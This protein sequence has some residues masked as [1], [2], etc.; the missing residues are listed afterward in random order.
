VTAR[1][2]GLFDELYD[3]AAIFP[4]G[5][6]PL[7]AAVPAHR[8]WL[9]SPHAATVGVF[10]CSAPRL[11]ELAGLGADFPVSVTVPDGPGG[12]PAV[13]ERDDLDVVSVEVP[14]TDDGGQALDRAVRRTQVYSEVRLADLTPSVAE[15][16]AAAGIHL[17]LRTGGA[18]AAMFPTAAALAGGIVTAVRAD[19][20]FKLTAGLH[21]ALRHRD[22][23]TGFE[24][25]GFGNVLAATAAALDGAPAPDVAAILDTTDAATVVARLRALSGAEVAAVRGRFRS[26]GTC[27]IQ[28]P[29]D[30][31]A[32]LGLL[33]A[34]TGA[35]A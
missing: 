2:G 20:P 10:V 25:H 24:H 21:H 34:A 13:L 33:P 11:D 31:L 4:P 26:F 14:L 18:D 19:L 12:L 5:N 15:R 32:A 9:S 17:K 7:E 35:D 22:P 16:L 8:A 28:E 23:A 6:A 1:P 27:S 3:D 29:L 30:D